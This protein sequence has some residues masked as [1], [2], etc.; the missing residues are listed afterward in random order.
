MPDNVSRF[1]DAVART[2]DPRAAARAMRVGLEGSGAQGILDAE[3]FRAI[4]VDKLCDTLDTCR[5]IIGQASL[6]SSL[7]RPCDHL[8]AIEARQEALRELSSRNDLRARL[9]AM[10]AAA[11]KGEAILY[12]LLFGAFTG[13]L[14]TAA[15]K[16]E[17]DGYGYAQYRHGTRF[18]LELSDT[19]RG[20]PEPAS[21][22]LKTLIDDLR[23]FAGSTAGALM[24]GPVYLTERGIRLADEKPGWWP[25]I[26]FR[27]SLFKPWLIIAF[28]LC[29]VLLGQF[30]PFPAG[31]PVS[32]LAGITFVL[33]LPAALLYVPAVGGFDRDQFVYPLRDRFRGME[34][35]RRVLAALGRIDA[36]LAVHRYAQSFGSATVLPK[37][38]DAPRH[39]LILRGARNPIL[40]FAN[41]DYVAN[42]IDL[43][44]TRLTFI[45]GP[46]SGGK[47]ALCKTIAQVQLLAQIGA[48]V[49]ASEA[50]AAIADRIYYQTPEA[51]SLSDAEGR[52]GTEL[53]RTKAIFLGTSPRS[54][55]ILDEMAEGTTYEEKLAISEAILAGFGSI[56]NSTVLIT[57]NHELVERFR[58]RKA[59]ACR[60]VEFAGEA[61]TYQ[62]IEGVSKVSHADRIAKRLGFS[63]EDIESNLRERG[64]A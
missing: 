40:G 43:E 59:A 31:L 10:L 1:F 63:R 18:L 3:T 60:Q 2:R 42:D 24:R 62:L 12:R 45:T 39:C 49:P 23:G 61:A 20:V 4:E 14:G 19:A 54:L 47:T 30:N 46:N 27:A 22:Y 15:G 41:H 34:E 29:V 56:G 6:Y 58:R 21:A 32:P 64:Y 50:E 16:L 52:F 37:I 7:C 44:G 53:A 17:F 57:H 36:L 33:L 9:E 35:V 55:V 38:V 11:E 28:A 5:T 25:A 48:Y 51:G 13:M 26:R 8:A